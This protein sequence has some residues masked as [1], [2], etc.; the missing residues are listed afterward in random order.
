[1]ITLDDKYRLQDF[2]YRALLDHEHQSIPN[3]RRKS[4]TI[5]GMPGRWDFG[6]EIDERNF[7]IPMKALDHDELE[8]QRKTNDINAFMLDEF[9]NPRPVKMTFDYEPDKYYTVKLDGDIIPVREKHSYSFLLPL[10]AYDPYK[11]SNTFADEVYWGSEVITFEYNYLLGREGVHGSVKVTGAQTLSVPVDGL[12]VQPIFEINGTANNLTISC[13][14]YSFILPNFTN[15]NWIIDFE[16]YVV[17]KNGKDTM[18]EI[19]DFYLMPD[20]NQVK[21]TGSNINIDIRIKYRDKFN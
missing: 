18:I 11:Y 2:G 8:L 21:I 5:P 3:I 16:K 14:T 15:V 19:R 13:G 7:S 17:F 9:G 12:A 6:T 1:M 4:L 10:A 20:N